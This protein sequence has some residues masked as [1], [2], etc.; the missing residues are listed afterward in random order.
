[1][2]LRP[3]RKTVPPCF[4]NFVQIQQ[5]SL[6]II[7]PV[8]DHLGDPW[9][10]PVREYGRRASQSRITSATPGEHERAL[11]G[12]RVWTTRSCFAASALCTLPDHLQTS[13]Q[14]WLTLALL[15]SVSFLSCLWP[16]RDWLSSSPKQKYATYSG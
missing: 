16:P 2:G 5:K 12:S 14:P 11:S 4:L 3:S 15:F 7:F 8:S 10:F 9:C 6:D 13:L 1:M